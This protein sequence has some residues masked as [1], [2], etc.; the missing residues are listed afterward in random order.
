MCNASHTCRQPDSSK[1]HVQRFWYLQIARVLL[2]GSA[3]FLLLNASFRDSN[4][5][6]TFCYHVL[7]IPHLWKHIAKVCKISTND[8]NE[9][10]F[11]YSRA[12][13]PPNTKTQK[14]NGLNTTEVTKSQFQNWQKYTVEQNTQTHTHI[15]TAYTT[16]TGTH[17]HTLTRHTTDT[18]THACR[19]TH[20]HTPKRLKPACSSIVCCRL[21]GV[22]P[23]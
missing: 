21:G 8:N 14:Q 11:F 5:P 1:C 20:A 4:Q 12:T 13:R 7:W 22:S 17:T 23:N 19:Y 6:L 3:D 16:H 15:G 9:T 18:R 10:F 2:H